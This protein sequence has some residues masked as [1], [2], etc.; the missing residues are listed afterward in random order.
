MP[1]TL[2]SLYLPT[3][4]HLLPP[5]TRPSLHLFLYPL[6]LC[7][8]LHRTTDSPLEING[9]SR[10]RLIGFEAN[11]HETQRRMELRRWRER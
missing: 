4:I 3:I 9:R 11:P 8:F 2:P 1:S 10:H 6:P 5:S 7:C